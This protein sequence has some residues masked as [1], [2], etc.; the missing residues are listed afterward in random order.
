MIWTWYR[1]IHPDYASLYRVGPVSAQ[2]GRQRPASQSVHPAGRTGRADCLK[3]GWTACRQAG[4]TFFLFLELNKTPPWPLAWCLASQPSSSEL[5]VLCFTSSIL[6]SIQ[7]EYLRCIQLEFALWHYC[8]FN[9]IPIPLPFAIFVRPFLIRYWH[10]RFTDWLIDFCSYQLVADR[11]IPFCLQYCFFHVPW[12]AGGLFHFKKVS[13]QVLFF[14]CL[15]YSSLPLL[16]RW[17]E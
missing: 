15:Y 11:L 14:E 8:N 3:A 4:R 17:K 7:L 16:R 12:L 9:P 10:C 2:R 5:L 13:H 6:L 1:H